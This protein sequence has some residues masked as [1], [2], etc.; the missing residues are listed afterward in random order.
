[1]LSIRWAVSAISFHVECGHN[2]NLQVDVAAVYIYTF[3]DYFT[4]FQKGVNLHCSN[5]Y[6]ENSQLLEYLS[7]RV[8]S[9]LFYQSEF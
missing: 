4:Q 3:Q 2:F 8:G 6:S 1:M 7:A 5:G 9:L